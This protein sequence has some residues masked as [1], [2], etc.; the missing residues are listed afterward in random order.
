MLLSVPTSVSL[1]VDSQ[2]PKAPIDDAG[3]VHEPAFDIPLS[4]YMSDEAKQAF[5]K[6]AAATQASNPD[7]TNIR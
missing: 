7:F 3:T 5:I 6:S 4:S 2:P 1:A